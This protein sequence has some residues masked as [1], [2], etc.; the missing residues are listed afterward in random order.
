[1]A[2]TDEDDEYRAVLA[3]ARANPVRSTREPSLRDSACEIVRRA[4]RDSTVVYADGRAVVT[5]TADARLR[6]D[7][8]FML[9]DGRVQAAAL[10][11]LGV[12]TVQVGALVGLAAS[13]RRAVILSALTAVSGGGAVPRDLVVDVVDAIAALTALDGFTGEHWQVT[14]ATLME[15]DVWRRPNASRYADLDALLDVLG[16]SVAAGTF[17]SQLL[18]PT[19]ERR[20]RAA[21][22]LRALRDERPVGRPV[23]PWGAA[24]RV[25]DALGLKMPKQSQA[26]RGK[27]RT[28]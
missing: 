7:L 23:T 25:A 8:D 3:W 20:S 17:P 6:D 1:M 4:V 13:S 11:E 26:T 18:R 10:E 24:A 28:E 21:D 2:L 9:Q 15:I 5:S 12:E 14:L 22:V 27:R 19:P 16:A